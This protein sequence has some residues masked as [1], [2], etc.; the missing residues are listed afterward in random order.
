MDYNISSFMANP[1]YGHRP[2]AS[3]ATPKDLYA[4][5]LNLMRIAKALS[6]IADPYTASETARMLLSKFPLSKYISELRTE[7]DEPINDDNAFKSLEQRVLHSVEGYDLT[8]L[9]CCTS[10][11][12]NYAIKNSHALQKN[13]VLSYIADSSKRVFQTKISIFPSG[14]IQKEIFRDVSIRSASTFPGFCS[15][16]ENRIFNAVENP[17]AKL[18]IKNSLVLLWRAMCFIRFRRAQELKNRA[19]SIF[20]DSLYQLAEKHQSK[21]VVLNQ[22][23]Y[24]KNSI[25]SYTMADKWVKFLNIA[26]RDNNNSFGLVALRVPNIPFVGAGLIPLPIDF[27]GEIHPNISLF[28]KEISSLSYTMALFEGFP[29]II[30]AYK[31]ADA[32]SNDFINSMPLLGKSVVSAYLPQIIIGGSDTVYIS[33]KY[34]NE[35][36]NLLDKHIMLHAHLMKFPSM[37]PPMWGGMSCVNI[38]KVIFLK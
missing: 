36:S 16:C 10:G 19:G 34:W 4:D 18:D 12:K 31:K 11:C 22:C 30:M 20:S 14:D 37:I 29:Y 38:D 17:N 27:N 28:N 33:K 3:K 26:M 9:K 15:E 7:I 5:Q 35:S 32:K 24:F 23:L 2:I 25:Y 1:Y 8:K 13:K 21:T 6:G